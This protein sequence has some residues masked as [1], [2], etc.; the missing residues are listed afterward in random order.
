M[1][2][3]QLEVYTCPLPHLCLTPAS[4]RHM[5]PLTSDLLHTEECLQSTVRLLESDKREA[6]KQ[7]LE[8]EKMLAI[9]KRQ[10]HKQM[11]T[12]RAQHEEAMS[13]VCVIE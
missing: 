13:K 7:V 10:F 1:Y 8:L 12:L 2:R 6:A 9:Q 11:E 4:P 3:E 5:P